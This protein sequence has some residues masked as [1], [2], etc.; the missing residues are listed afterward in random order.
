MSI[1]LTPQQS[2]AYEFIRGRIALRGFGP[3]FREIARASGLK[4]ISGVARLLNGLE[5]R[6]AIRRPL[7]NR[8]RAIELIEQP[9]QCPHCGRTADA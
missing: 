5:E 3:S 2:R 8:R 9:R 7:H 6:G 1:S 4:S